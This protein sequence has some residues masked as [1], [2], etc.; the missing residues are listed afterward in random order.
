MWQGWINGFLWQFFSPEQHRPE[1]VYY[2]FINITHF[3][4]VI[5][6]ASA[7]IP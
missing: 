6:I 3:H 4:P 1:P 2:S 7:L 5:Y